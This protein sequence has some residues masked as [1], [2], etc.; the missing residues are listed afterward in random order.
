MIWVSKC[1]AKNRPYQT[2]SGDWREF[3]QTGR[4]GEWGSTEWR[5]EVAEVKNGDTIIA[6]QT[7]RNELVGVARAVDLKLR[8]RYQDLILKPVETIGVKVRPLKSADPRIAAIRALQ[9]GPIRTLYP[10]SRN[11]ARWLLKKAG[12]RSHADLPNDEILG[13]RSASN[14]GGGFGTADQNRE[15]ELAAVGFVTSY[16]RSR[17]W[18]VQDI[19]TENR[20]YDLV[21]KRNGK[22]LDIEVKGVAGAK[23]QFL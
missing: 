17:G 19:E 9:P 20:G 18:T 1:N 7:D 3:F 15:T 4:I 6:Y 10:I 12:A 2:A 21:C 14:M 13:L 23:R 22:R 5:P 16:F 11:D 8:G